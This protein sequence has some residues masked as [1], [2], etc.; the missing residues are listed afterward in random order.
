MIHPKDALLSRLLRRKVKA[1]YTLDDMADDVAGLLDALSLRSAHIMGMSLGGMVAQCLALRHPARVRS[2]TLVMTTPGELWAQLPSIKALRALVAPVKR[3]REG[4]IARQVEFFRQVGH[5]EH[6]VP[7]Q[8]LIELSGLHFDRG[9]HPRGF[10]RQFAAVM[11]SPGRLPQLRKVRIP[12]LVVHGAEDPLIHPLGG[13]LLAATIPGARLLLV[14]GMGHELGPSVWP[15][16]IDALIENAR[17]VEV[18][19]K[20]ALS[21]LGALLQRPRKIARSGRSQ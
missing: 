13:R 10:A 17:R 5:P 2:L 19:A 12:T 4:F 8:R 20:A 9:F 6:A 7:E 3:T 1:G 14:Q 11:A 21:Q 18:P 15:T 16:V